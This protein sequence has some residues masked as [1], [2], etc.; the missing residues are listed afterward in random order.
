MRRFTPTQHAIFWQVAKSEDQQLS[1]LVTSRDWR[2]RKNGARKGRSPK[3][4]NAAYA[5][6]KHGYLEIVDERVFEH[7]FF[8]LPNGDPDQRTETLFK[9]GLK[10]RE[11]LEKLDKTGHG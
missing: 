5:L 3:D 10:G 8:N 6:V 1:I 11:Y 2:T 9:I 4:L 7:K